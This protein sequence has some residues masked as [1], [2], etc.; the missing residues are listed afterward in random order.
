MNT[1]SIVEIFREIAEI[2]AIKG[3]NPFRIRAY[4]RAAQSIEG[5]GEELDKFI[6]EDTLTTIAGIG[7]DLARQI[8][9]I[10]TTGKSRKLESLKKEVPQGV[11]DML[12]ISGLGP[13][14]V[15]LIYDKLNIKTIDK[16]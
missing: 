7:D 14:T 11:I 15:H 16:L 10:A 3:E 2:L 8:K 4:D 5:L 12:K 9:E 13:K 6:K 1:Q